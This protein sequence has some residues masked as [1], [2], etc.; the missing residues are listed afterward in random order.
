MSINQI[1]LTSTMDIEELKAIF[2]RAICVHGA[3]DCNRHICDT[4]FGAYASVAKKSCSFRAAKRD[5]NHQL[6]SN[7]E[8]SADI[9]STTQATEL[10]PLVHPDDL[11]YFICSFKL[12]D[13]TITMNVWRGAFAISVTELITP[14]LTDAMFAAFE[15]AIATIMPHAKVERMP[16]VATLNALGTIILQKVHED[17]YFYV[18]TCRKVGVGTLLTIVLRTFLYF[19]N[20]GMTTLRHIFLSLSNV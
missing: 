20:S 14:R 3:F 18:N 19:I 1:P 11:D 2:M 9:P 13:K 17:M 10:L 8:G 6:K 7:D 12:D 5:A 15:R 16:R 4:A